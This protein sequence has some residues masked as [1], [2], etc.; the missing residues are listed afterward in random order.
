MTEFE[1]LAERERNRGRRLVP[2][3]IERA[4]Y[5]YG[6]GGI[7]PFSEDFKDSMEHY[8]INGLEPG[9]FATAMLA[10]DLER[11]LY[12]A[13][14]YNRQVFWAIAMWVRETCPPQATGSYEAVRAWCKNE[15]GCRDRYKDEL[16]KAFAWK[17]LARP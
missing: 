7:E 1:Q 2:F 16:E 8:L 5:H 4:K 17:Q 11:A 13:D 12:N 3:H 14:T 9:G 15:N 6:D 10:H